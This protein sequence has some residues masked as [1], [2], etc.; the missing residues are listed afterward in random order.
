MQYDAEWKVK[1]R[2]AMQWKDDENDKK[3]MKKEKKRNK[4]AAKAGAHDDFVILSIGEGY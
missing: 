3:E 4:R 2:I 1:Q